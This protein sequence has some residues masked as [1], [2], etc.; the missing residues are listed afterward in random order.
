MQKVARW[1]CGVCGR[2]VGSNSIQCTSCQKWVY[3]KCN[4]IKGSMAKVMAIY[5]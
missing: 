5:L 4:G 1:P 3:K 2:V